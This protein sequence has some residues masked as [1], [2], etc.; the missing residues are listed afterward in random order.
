[1]GAT[2]SVGQRG[3]SVTVIGFGS[4]FKDAQMGGTDFVEA[5]QAPA[6][7]GPTAQTSTSG[8]SD[9]F[10]AILN[11]KLWPASWRRT[12]GRHHLDAEQPKPLA[13]LDENPLLQGP[14]AAHPI[15][16]LFTSWSPSGLTTR[17]SES[18]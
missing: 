14:V 3:G 8:T 11:G 16:P 18:S 1:M 9:L 2:L 15:Q 5:R 13:Q 12:R 10:P 7:R 17:V 6:G 4:R